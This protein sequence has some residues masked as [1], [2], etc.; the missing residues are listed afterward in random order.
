M[1]DKERLI[2]ALP[3]VSPGSPL[4]KSI[5]GDEAQLL[6]RRFNIV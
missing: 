4:E 3:G 5:D 6:Q 2:S 1:G